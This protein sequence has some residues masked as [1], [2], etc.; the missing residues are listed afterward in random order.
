MRST[1]TTNAVTLAC[2]VLFFAACDDHASPIGITDA[3]AARPPSPNVV[4]PAASATVLA[5]D[6][7]TVRAPLDPYFINQAP[8]F[9]IRS[10]VRSDLVIQRL[11]T[12]P[13][14][15]AWHTH[16][17][18]SFGIVEQGHVMIT[19][20]TDHGCT[21]S[22]YGP[23]EA[24]FEVAGQVHRASVVGSESAV[25]H[26]VRFNTPVGGAFTTPAADPGC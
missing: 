11:V 16:P 23:G 14:P 18:P 4:L 20:Y 5:V 15:G 26:K 1:R 21:T 10:H 6:P 22:V 25:E 13:G 19:R 12:A 8:D 2:T 24:Y 7:F 3:D 17:G 9:M